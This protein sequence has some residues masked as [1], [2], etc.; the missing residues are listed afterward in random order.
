MNKIR[1]L[2]V[3]N[4]GEIAIRV[5]RAASELGMR[6]IAIYSNED[7]FALHRFKADESYLVGAG[8]KPIQAYLD[9]DD[10]I[11]VAREAGVDGVEG[12]H[13]EEVL[14]QG[15]D[16][17]F[18]DTIALGL[19]NEGG[20]A[21]DAK[22]GDLVLEVAGQVVGAVV[23]A[24]GET[25]GHVPLDAA[26]VAQ[27][28]LAH[29]LERLEAVAGA[30]GVASTGASIAGTSLACA[31]GSASSTGAGVALGLTGGVAVAVAAISGPWTCWSTW[32][33]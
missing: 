25:L 21:L 4:R 17:A 27:N 31:G 23:V 14:L 24:Q 7:R 33:C 10:V 22:E 20:R 1:S 6:T 16:E 28:A 13:P 2:L 12:V 3:A 26:E 19:A 9:I 8:K 32:G 18:R 29:R 11:R 5:L 15:A 30:G